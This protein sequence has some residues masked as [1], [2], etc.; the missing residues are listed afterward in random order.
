[1]S[2]PIFHN[3]FYYI[4]ETLPLRTRNQLSET[5]DAHGGTPVSLSNP[6]LTHFITSS[7]ALEDFVESLPDDSRAYTVT[8]FWVERC[9]IL[10]SR[11]DPLCYSP[12]PAYL[13]SGVTATATGLTKPDCELMSAAIS[14]LGGQWRTILTNEVTHLFAL[15]PEGPAYETAMRFAEQTKQMCVLVPHWFDDTVRLGIRDLPTRYYEWP[16]PRVFQQRPEGR[17]S[18]EDVD[19]EPSPERLLLY[20]T[21]TLSN[22]DQKKIRPAPRNVWKGKRLLLG[23]SLELSDSQK[24]ALHTDIRRQ[25]GELVELSSAKYLSDAERARDEL[26]KLDEADIFVTRFRSGAAYAK[27]YQQKKTIGTLA[28]L[29]YV[30]ASGTL[31]RPA[32]QL[33]HYPI[34]NH[35]A[36]GFEKEIITV[37]NYTGKDREYL[38]TLI[39]LMGGKFTPSMTADKNTAVVAAFMSGVKTDKATSWSIPIVNH[40]WVEDC[41]VQ[42]RRLTPARDKYITFPPGVDFST[43][44]AERGLGKITWEPGQLEEMQRVA[45]EATTRTPRKR[46]KSK[47]ASASPKKVKKGAAAPEDASP[48]PATAQSVGEVEQAVAMDVEEGERDLS[49]AG[50]MDVDADFSDGA[51]QDVPMVMNDAPSPSKVPLSKKGPPSKRAKPAA[52]EIPSK[53]RLVRRYASGQTDDEAAPGEGAASAPDAPTTPSRKRPARTYESASAKAKRTRR[54]QEGER[55]ESPSPTKKP[56]SSRRKAVAED[57]DVAMA[58][59]LSEDEASKAKTKGKEKNGIVKEKEPPVAQSKKSKVIDLI[60]SDSDSDTEEDDMRSVLDGL[61]ANRKGKAR[62]AAAPPAKAGKSPQRLDSVLLPTVSSVYRSPTKQNGKEDHSSATNAP[63]KIGPP[64]KAAKIAAS[65]AEKSEVPRTST[66]KTATRPQSPSESMST[67][68]PPPQRTSRRKSIVENAEAGPSRATTST[69]PTKL[70]RTPSKRSAATKATQKLHDV[71]MPDVNS[72]QKEMKK[73]AVRGIHEDEMERS[74]SKAK[75][76][77]QAKGR[78][79]PSIGS[80]GPEEEEDEDEEEMPDRKKRKTS[81]VE[82]VEKDKGR[83]KKKGAGPRKSTTAET[84]DEGH[85]AVSSRK[86]GAA[87]ANDGAVAQAKNVRVM[88]TQLTLSD[89]VVKQLNKMGVKMVTKP[90]ECTHLLVKSVVRTEKFL[91]AMAV[92]PYVLGEKWARM[93]AFNRKLLPEDEFAIEDEE[94]EKKYHFNLADA[95]KRAKRNAGKLF[96]G[97]TF[98]VTPK[99][100]VDTKLLKNVVAANGGQLSTQSPTV[101]VLAGHDNRYVISC[102]EDVSIWRPLAQHD[103]KIYTQELIL[104]SALRQEIDWDEEAYFVPG[105]Y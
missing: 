76:P 11:Q 21:A 23:L 34:P 52:E 55:A 8:P 42:W 100:P 22:D 48:P 25:G 84:E 78:K 87:T 58:E 94:T 1:M 101:R 27:A 90:S 105:S 5:L 98:Y 16:E 30:R 79:R 74:A 83:G 33:L 35:P 102:P 82:L 88:T 62:A 19:Y 43:V 2:K 41:F 92:A 93:S 97:I 77:A 7:L 96:S 53:R 17:T 66:G 37:S 40:T 69:S 4:S 38:K 57:D 80:V 64:R 86:S 3:V 73:G 61:M 71:I 95:L 6:A 15:V 54:G 31:T 9:A 36:D 26:A 68:P 67:P 14:A 49:L 70:M 29:W 104:T 46:R 63:M 32:D 44:L 39:T 91:C 45:D 51:L 65:A 24:K 56:R 60:S 12:D 20:E 103:H 18:Q 72:F 13:F 81:D 28:W 75:T 59:E 10:D 85:E 99:V 89:D 47:S 50:R